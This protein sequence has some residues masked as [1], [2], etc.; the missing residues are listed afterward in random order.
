M[1]RTG[2]ATEREVASNAAAKVIM[3]IVE[4]TMYV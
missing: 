4:R 2:K 1:E 3:H